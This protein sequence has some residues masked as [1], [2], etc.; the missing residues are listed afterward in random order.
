MLFCPLTSF[1]VLNHF[2][3]LRLGHSFIYTN[4]QHNKEMSVTQEMVTLIGKGSNYPIYYYSF[5]WPIWALHTH[6]FYYFFQWSFRHRFFILNLSILLGGGSTLL[7]YPQDPLTIDDIEQVTK[8][9]FNHG[10]SISDVN[11]VRKHL[12]VLKGGGLAKAAAPAQVGNCSL[13]FSFCFSV[14]FSS[15]SLP[16]SLPPSLSLSLS[17]L[18][19]TT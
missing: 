1:L 3:I 15:P 8:Q 6:L 17:V 13:S 12:E 10:A 2:Y 9:L 4:V 19:T 11:T 5:L 7:P 14:F 16:P 18:D